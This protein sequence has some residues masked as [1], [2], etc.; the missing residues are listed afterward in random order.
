MSRAGKSMEVG[1][2]WVAA[3]GW[4]GLGVGGGGNEESDH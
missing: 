2:R 4:D 1:S 3:Q